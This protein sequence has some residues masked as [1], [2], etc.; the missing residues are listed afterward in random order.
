MMLIPAERRN[1]IHKILHDKG[2]VSVSMLSAALDVSEITIRRDLEQMEE[3]G[4]LERT[5]GGAILNQRIH[6]ELLYSEKHR[7][8]PT[9]KRLIGKAAAALVEDNDTLLIHSG[10]TTLEIFR[11]LEDKRNVR[12]ITS[13]MSAPLEL[14][15]SQ[16]ELQMIGGQFRPQS[17]SLVG[18]LAMLSLAQVH[19]SKSFIGVDGVSLKYGLTTPNIQEAEVARM[20]IERTRGEVIVV[21]DHTKFGVVADFLSAPLEKI[22]TIVTDAQVNPEFVERLKALG[23]RMIIAEE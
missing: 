9:E 14:Q 7:A 23:I 21:A 22:H 3:N 8:H 11:H 17:N 4:L 13:N 19:S 1:R 16:V 12:I 15:N 2:I 20:M 10:S 18:P 6:L 5:H